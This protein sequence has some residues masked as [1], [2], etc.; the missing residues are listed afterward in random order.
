MIE[1]KDRWPEGRRIAIDS[2][3]IRAVEMLINRHGMY[4]DAGT[5]A[6]IAVHMESGRL[7][8]TR[9]FEFTSQEEENQCFDAILNA[10]ISVGGSA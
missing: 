4:G 7:D 5:A 6:I 8:F 10:S 9:T 2:K 1:I 3:R